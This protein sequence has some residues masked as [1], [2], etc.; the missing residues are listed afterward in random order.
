M[1]KK[2]LM[3]SIMVLAMAMFMMTACGGSLAGEIVDEKTMNITAEN[4]G[5]GDFIMTGTLVVTEDEQ[6]TIDSQLDKGG[7]KIEFIESAGD[8]DMEE[9]PDYENAE[10]T[11]TANVSGIESQAVSFGAGE[12]MVKVT[13]AEKGT[14][15]TVNVVIKGF[16]E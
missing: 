11:Y 2:L 12:F 13:A 6:I 14:T 4:A 7:V 5:E 9:V 10:A 8:E 16:G 15:G 1:K 3:V